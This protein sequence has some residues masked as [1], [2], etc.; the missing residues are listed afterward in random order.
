MDRQV[1]KPGSRCRRASGPGILCKEGDGWGNLYR[2]SEAF[3]LSIKI[4]L[5]IE[6]IEK[7][8]LIWNFQFFLKMVV[9][10]PDELKLLQR[11]SLGLV[12][13]KQRHLWLDIRQQGL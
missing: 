3:S 7:F 12:S 8:R 13:R 10:F 9:P 4:T 11:K 6:S 5:A 2:R 1:G